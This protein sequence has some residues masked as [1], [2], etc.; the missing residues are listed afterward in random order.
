[1]TPVYIFSLPRSGSTLLQRIIAAHSSVATVSEPWLLLPMLY[2]REEEGVYA[3]YN[4]RGY[5]QANRDFRGN[6]PEGGEDMD[7]AIREYATY[8]YDRVSPDDTPFFLDKTPRYHLIA[9]RVMEVFEE[10][11]FVFLW[12]SPLSIVASLLRMDQSR[13]WNLPHYKIDLFKGA[14]NLAASYRSAPE[15]HSLK[16]ED[17]VADPMKE[18]KKIFEYIGVEPSSKTVEE[19]SRVE[20]KG[21]LGDPTGTKK[22]QQVSRDPLEKW[23]T[24]LNNP[25]RK[26]WVKRYLRWIGEADLQTMGYDMHTLIN[27]LNR[28]PTN[29][30]NFFAD[31]FGVVRGGLRPW[32]EP[33]IVKDKVR[34]YRKTREIYAHS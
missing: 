27:D 11:K 19:F 15:V 17:L 6:L 16:Y 32:I 22:Y 20:L 34:D 10:G 33:I 8:L 18:A 5:V 3:E 30:H 12:R 7:T 4:H 29:M 13:S 28:I 31:A 23:K 1:M 26:W 2:M 14:R 25:V 24:T 21:Q 9:D